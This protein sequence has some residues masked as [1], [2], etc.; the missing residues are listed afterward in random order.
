M[1]RHKDKGRLPP[2]V[3]LHISTMETPAW[4]ALSMG[5]RVLYVQM[6]RHHFVGIKNN[7]GKIYLSLRDAMEEIGICDHHSITR[8]FR[9][10]QHY[11]F[12]V[13]VTEGCLGVDGK[14][15]APGW[16]L[17]ELPTP[18]A[19]ETQDYLKWNGTPFPGNGNQVWRGRGLKPKKQ[20][21]EG[22]TTSRVRWKQPAPVRW[23]QP[24]LGS[25]SEVKTTLISAAG[26][27][28]ETT[29]ISRITTGVAR[30]WGAVEEAS[31]QTKL[32]WSTPVLTE[33]TDP[34]EARRIQ[35]ELDAYDDVPVLVDRIAWPQPPLTR[36]AA[37]CEKSSARFRV[38]WRSSG[39][40]G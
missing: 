26:G 3:P 11:G 21:P 27:E 19:R 30:G 6:K 14:G 8:W 16:R 20:N 9:E 37:G 23:K 29:P 31:P 18:A 36:P 1:S 33:V 25:Q 10:L 4:K 39:A 12:I 7:N 17:T 13:K 40:G 15:K 38:R 24:A 32:P 34:D 2:F 22:C 28:V 35:E 5:A